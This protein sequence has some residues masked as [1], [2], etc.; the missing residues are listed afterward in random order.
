MREKWKMSNIVH[1]HSSGRE[2]TQNYF[3]GPYL[4]RIMKGTTFP[5]SG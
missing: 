1:A 3:C 2:Q 5:D 4:F